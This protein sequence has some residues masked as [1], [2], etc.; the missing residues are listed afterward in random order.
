[1]EAAAVVMGR[2]TPLRR[3]FKTEAEQIAT[4]VRAE[5]RLGPYQRFDPRLLA[6]HLGIEVVDMTSLAHDGASLA[7]IRHFQGAGKEAFSAGTLVSGHRRI[8]VVNDA[9]AQVRQASSLG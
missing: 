9:H 6:A 4:E 7:S 1:M 2:A 5:L 8:I 3:G